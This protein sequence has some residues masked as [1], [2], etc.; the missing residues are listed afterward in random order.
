[1]FS[2]RKPVFTT[3]LVLVF[4]VL[5][6]FSYRRLKVDLFPEVSF[7]F[8]TVTTLYPGAGPEEVETQI[9]EKIEDEVIAIANVRRV[10]SVSREN[11]SLIFIEFELGTK[12]DFAAIEVK[13]K[14]DAIRFRLPRNAE[15]PS[16]LKFD[17]GAIPVL[18]LALTGTLPLEE[19]FRLADTKVKEAFARVPGVSSVTVIGGK[20]REIHVELD[21]QQLKGYGL[22]LMDVYQ[23]IATSN[24]SVPAGRITRGDS[25]Y[26]IRLLGEFTNLN[27]L[28][29]LRIPTPTGHLVALS[30]VGKVV[31]SFKE[32]RADARLDGVPSVGIS[33]QKRSD[34]NVVET[35]N[36]ARKTIEA[37]RQTLPA[38]VSLEIVRDTSKFIRSA[39]RDVLVSLLLGVLLTSAVLYLFLHDIRSTVI[40]TLVMPASI[41]ATF[42]LMDFAGFTLNLMSLLGLGISI[43][44]L[45]ANAIVVLESIASR[46][47]RGEPPRQAAETG[48]RIVWLAVTASALTNVVVFVPI[49]FMSGIVGQFFKQFGLTVVFATMF[50]LFVSFTLTPM[51]ASRLLR[52]SHESVQRSLFRGFFRAWDRAFTVFQRGYAKSLRWALEHRFLVALGTTV[53]FGVGVF[54]FRFIG[55]DFI[56]KFYANE[57]LVHVEMPAGSS[58]ERTNRRIQHIEAV[59]KTLPETRGLYSTLGRSGSGEEGVEY[60]QVLVRLDPNRKRSTETILNELRSKLLAEV[61]DVE[62]AFETS[63]GAQGSAYDITIEIQGPEL[64][65]LARLAKSIHRLVEETPGLADVHTNFKPGKPEL[66]IRLDRDRLNAYRLSMA[67]VGSLLRASFSGEVASLFREKGE[68]YDILV[69]LSEKDRQHIEDVGRLLVRTS[70]TA[71]PLSELGVVEFRGGPTQLNHTNKLRTVTVEANIVQGDLGSALRT[72]KAKTDALDLPPGYSVTYTGQAERQAES[73]ASILTALVIAII[74]TYMVL[75]ALLESFVHPFTIM[76]TLPLGLVGA[77]LAL[78]ISQ[79]MLNIFSLMA[80]VMLVGIIVNNAILL[81]DLT[82]QLRREGM[83]IREA[84]MEACPARFRPILMTNLAIVAGMLP[85]A[86]SQGDVAVVQASMA[87]VMM[88]AVIVSTAFTLYTIPVVYIWFDKLAKAPNGGQ[89]V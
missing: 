61:P 88:G 1:M 29:D 4:L 72:L 81:L 12:V 78:V 10:Q 3:M 43:G 44:T 68:E 23:T 7:P 60:G 47:E 89:H 82:G 71:I 58:L 14:V 87:V 77:S 50:S 21:N 30:D 45:V 79:L 16:V 6:A 38:D 55:S 26:S 15:D 31:D 51:L 59:A 24:L 63:Q 5:G 65:E 27:T 48:T 35:V 86:L 73:F 66:V 19:L 36:E 39:V 67:Q 18:D 83:G 9:T 76:M 13:D 80:L 32:Q 11:V 2:V 49:G 42:L 57:I 17:I 85:Q 69:R 75:A 70:G 8:V 52:P 74:L 34:A 41:F 40:V 37:L 33:I 25:E 64:T 46:L 20:E 53:A 22:T 54:L 84:L 28:A 62:L 56:P